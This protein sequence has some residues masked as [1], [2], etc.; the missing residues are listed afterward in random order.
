M[1]RK[2]KKVNDQKS[3]WYGK[4]KLII[5]GLQNNN[6]IKKHKS[7]LKQL[8]HTSSHP[9]KLLKHNK[10]LIN[11]HVGKKQLPFKGFQASLSTGS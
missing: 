7:N 10:Y 2:E 6:H 9:K 8:L 4:H 11:L 3:K 5:I 1:K